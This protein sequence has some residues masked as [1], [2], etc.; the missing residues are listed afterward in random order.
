VELRDDKAK[1]NGEIVIRYGSLDE[2]DR[3]LDVL[4]R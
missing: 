2:L 1:G 4:L 3:L